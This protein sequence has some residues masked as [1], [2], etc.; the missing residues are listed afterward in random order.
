MMKNKAV[1]SI[2]DIKRIAEESEEKYLWRLGQAKDSGLLEMDWNAI[3]KVMNNEFRDSESEYRTEAAYRKRYTEAKKFYDAG[4]FKQSESDEVK[5]LQKVKD[6]IFKAKKQLSDQRRE[7]NKVLTLEARSDH[8][9]EKMIEAAESLNKDYPL[10]FT[11]YYP[12]LDTSGKEALICFADWHYGMVTDNIWNK[13]N[14]EICKE[15]ISK[16]ITHCMEYL[17]LNKITTVHVVLLGD[18]LNGAIHTTSRV[19]SEED[20][21]DQLMNVA[22]LIAQAITIIS[23]ETEKVNVYTCCG[24]HARTI[25]NKKESVHSDNMEK[26]IPWWLRQRLQNNYKVH[27]IDSEYKEFTKIN[28]LGKNIICVHGDLEHFKNLGVTV[29]T[30]FSQKFGETIDYT[31]SADK[32]HLEEIGQFAIESILVRSLCGTDDHANNGRLYDKPGQTMIVFNN[33]YGRE[34]TYHVPLN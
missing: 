4:V 34:S 33:D 31:V 9:T 3:A 19:K 8:L 24:N 15:R 25:Q 28:I 17:Y 7:Y 6:E 1:I 22:E 26:I 2:F 30:I 18:M 14:T 29:N 10:L 12:D 32:H 20:T 5:E 16:F 21:C 11:E 23:S 13:Y 27:I